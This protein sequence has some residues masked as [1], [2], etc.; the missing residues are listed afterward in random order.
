MRWSVLSKSLLLI[1][2]GCGLL[3]GLDAAAG[4]S[5]ADPTPRTITQ[6]DGST[7]VG[8]LFGD[9]Y[10][11]GL[12]TDAGF[13]V[14]QDAVG[15][16][17]FAEATR[18]GRL[19]STGL[20]PGPSGQPPAS[21]E[22]TP[23][24]RD[25]V[26]LAEAEDARIETAE[27]AP[28][29]TPPA[30]GTQPVLVI[31]AQFNDRALTTT[32]TDWSARWFGTDQSVA[33]YYDE[34]SFG[35]LDLEP[36]TES[37]TALGGRADDGVV[38]V[39]VPTAHPNSGSNFAVF[40]D[41]VNGILSDSQLDAAVDFAAYDTDNDNHI[42]PDELHLAVVVAGTE[43][44]QGCSAPSI[45]AHRNSLNH[46]VTVDT[47]I[48]LGDGSVNGGFLA[49]GELQCDLAVQQATLGIWVHELGH[50]LGL[51][52]LYDGDGSSSGVDTWSVMGLHWLNLPGEPIGTR[53][54]LP[55]PFSRSQLGWLMPTEV[56][57]T[58]DDVTLASS[59]SSD[60]VAQV[61]A[62]PDGVDIGFLGGGG[63]GEYFLVENREQEGYD[64]AARGCGL[65]VWHIDE[66]HSSN[67]DDDA[68]LVDVEEAG[69]GDFQ[70]GS[71]DPDDP[72][73]SENP[74][75]ALFDPTS[76]PSSSLNSGL[77]SGV[78][79]SGFS[80]TC[81]S[82]LTLD[83]EPGGAPVGPPSND[84]LDSARPI[85]LDGT[86][87][88]SVRGHNVGATHEVGEPQHNGAPGL[89]SIWYSFRAPRAGFVSL[90]TES[91]FQEVAAVYTGTD[92]GS[93]RRVAS[94]EAVPPGGGA[95]SPAAPE[96][97][98]RGLGIRVERGVRYL[99]AIDARTPGDTGGVRV[100]LDYDQARTDV[101]PVRRVVAAGEQPEL[102]VRIR[103]TSSFD[104]LRVYQLAE[105]TTALPS[106]DCPESFL[107]APGEARMCRV[108]TTVTGGPGA[109]LRGKVTAWIEW[110]DIGRYATIADPWF[111]RV[112]A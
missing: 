35:L 37:D 103:N 107:L 90:T 27:A 76:S 20:R 68:R 22:L 84:Q 17:T 99:V 25:T 55:D 31:L 95:G 102:R 57:T 97:I 16:W 56:T 5:P 7:F 66:S 85:P 79:L 58:S 52:D 82:S 74:P 61:L 59:A 60:D 32:P 73:P 104:T 72:Y 110:P 87:L 91:T 47:D 80:P 3:V 78:A 36:A 109:S 23:H 62:N 93:L 53:P 39:D 2:I 14:V 13:T 112:Q 46:P 21:A 33:D 86:G 19:R 70:D 41:T 111:A 44:A 65:L 26:A 75:N 63:T 54:P 49:G 40:Q 71:A 105:G 30:T 9:E 77:P 12:E 28:A 15:T 69:G 96:S 83:V 92:M 10:V 101:R 88:V 42:S 94:V 81:G 1:G 6:P 34:A 106:L 18:T 43:A 24:L 98:T 50:D 4:A 11:N 51:L 45:W 64:I 29:H 100:F 108:R 89:S 48:L 38:V 8:R 67:G